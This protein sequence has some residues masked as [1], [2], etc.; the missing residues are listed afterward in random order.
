MGK[1]YNYIG[2]LPWPV[3]SSLVVPTNL[4]NIATVA[5]GES[6]GLALLA[7]GPPRLT[8]PRV[9]INQSFYAGSGTLLLYGSATGKLPL[10][11]QWQ[12]KWNEPARRYRSIAST[13]KCATTG[14]G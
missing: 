12:L 13:N 14:S 5:V 6:D 8:T 4:S 1:Y 3:D 2:G 11:Y 9:K 7:N 10:S